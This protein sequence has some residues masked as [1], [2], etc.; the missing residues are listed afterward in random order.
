MRHTLPI[1]LL[2]AALLS[3]CQ[4]DQ[5]RA[6]WQG[7]DAGPLPD[8]QKP[9]ADE[10]AK[11]VPERPA[12]NTVCNEHG[13]CWVH[14]S[15]FPGG[16][17]EMERVGDRVFAVA[18]QPSNPKRSQTPV[19]LT[20]DLEV[21]AI[22]VPEDANFIDLT[23]TQSGWI[24]L[25]D[26]GYIRTFNEEESTGSLDL[27]NDEKYE[28][29]SAASAEE[30]LVQTE[31]GALVH[32]HHDLT[33]HER[34]SSL[35]KFGP[36]M[37]PN[38]RIMKFGEAPAAWLS[39][40]LLPGMSDVDALGPAP[41]SDCYAGGPW[42]AHRDELFLW[43]GDEKT[44]QGPTQLESKILGFGCSPG[45][46]V[47][48]VDI[49]GGVNRY[50][51]GGWQRSQ[52]SS[53]RLY[54]AEPLES[55]TLLGGDYGAFLVSNGRRAASASSGFRID[56]GPDD[57]NAPAYRDLWVNSDGTHAALMH[58]TGFYHGK[59][60][61]G[62]SPQDYGEGEYV[63]TLRNGR[64]IWGADTPRFA[65]TSSQLLEWSGTRWEQPADADQDPPPA[66]LDIAGPKL[67]SVW[68]VSRNAIHR[69]DGARWHE[70][71]SAGSDLEQRIRD[72]NLK[73][74][75]VFVAQNGDVL[76][77]GNKGIYQVTGHADSWSLERIADTPCSESTV[78]HR[79]GD[80]LIVV[81]G[82]NGCMARQYRDGWLSYSSE[83][84][85]GEDTMPHAIAAQ[86]GHRPLL[87]AHDEGLIELERD[88][89]AAI[90]F[91]GPVHDVEYV[92]GRDAMLLIQDRGVAAKFF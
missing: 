20:E 5:N 32:D 60:P 48:A 59:E 37:A 6:S 21:E 85:F 61:R 9:P 63:G 52:M 71:S 18:T 70:V 14:P 84:D 2:C 8:I 7:T 40:P 1:L 58:I 29:V 76:I 68:T 77:G 86:P 90:Q 75:S 35:D 23:T 25:T 87:L 31:R 46:D 51:G 47:L 72:E 13:W 91:D 26:D 65:L 57:L 44:W 50:T 73:F 22:D 15:P 3:S 19:I 42:A 41:G 11:V 54:D 67:D 64:E 39:F 33:S 56:F 30:Y 69:Y 82:P 80:G 34:I 38:G 36:E 4:L 89:D 16:I 49:D 27:L 10:H 74:S 53:R 17:D 81:A 79:T 83:I 28:R 88:A 62:W 55:V 92:P 12:P 66:P 78:L 45:G 43:N 24:G